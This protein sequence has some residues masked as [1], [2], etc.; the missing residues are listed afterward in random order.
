MPAQHK[1]TIRQIW[2]LLPANNVAACALQRLMCPSGIKGEHIKAIRRVYIE[3]TATMLPDT[4][5]QIILGCCFIL[6]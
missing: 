6:A 4:H 1:T 3:S 5:F 2:Q